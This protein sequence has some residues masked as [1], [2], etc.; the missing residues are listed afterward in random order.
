MRRY[1]YFALS[2]CVTLLMA[3]G[4]S[5]GQIVPDAPI[6]D[7][8]LL[9]FGDNGY[10][11]WEIH[12]EE[13]HYISDQ[14]I[15]VLGLTIRLFNGTEDLRV[16]TIIESPLASMFVEEKEAA[17]DSE[18]RITGGYFSIEGKNWTWRGRTRTIEVREAVEVI[19]HEKLTDILK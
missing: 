3:R 17:G 8:R 13:G 6:V 5:G 2:A 16:E 14:R 19:F 11:I 9:M 10:K 7:F 15:D 18:L 12:G 1:L 4:I